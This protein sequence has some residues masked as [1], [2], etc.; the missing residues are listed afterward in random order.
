MTAGLTRILC[1]TDGSRAS[2]KGVTYAVWLAKKLGASLTLLTVNTGQASGRPAERVWDMEIRRLGEEQIEHALHAA[3]EIAGREGMDTVRCAE[4]HGP[5]AAAAIIDFA[6]REGHDH[7]VVG[8]TGRTG[9]PRLL[10]GSVAG[11]I[12]AKAHCP[13]T[14]VR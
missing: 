12:V 10:L 1:P 7:I 14:V 13:V 8:S 6:E 4:V 2:E 9:V 11:D 5:N 3:S